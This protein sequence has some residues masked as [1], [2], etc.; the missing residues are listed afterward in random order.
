[1]THAQFV[2]AYHSGTIRVDIDRA[3]AAR[4]MSGRLL[5]PLVM[6][7]VLGIGTAL[8]I[9]GWIWVGLAIIGLA[10]I[11]PMLI[12]RSAPHFVLTQA[13]EDARFYDDVAGS[14]LLQI[15]KIRS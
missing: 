15:V 2:A 9:L 6:L 11:A 1:M 3:A 4:Y 8:A 5:L 13:L 14:G 10:T 12:K 7:P